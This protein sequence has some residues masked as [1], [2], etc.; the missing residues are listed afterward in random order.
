MANWNWDPAY[1]VGIEVIDHQHKRLLQYINEL[2]AAKIYATAESRQKVQEILEKHSSYTISHFSFEEK[3]MED[4]GYTL[5]EPHKRVHEAFIERVGFFK[6]RHKNGEDIGKQLAF[7]LQIWLLNHIKQEDHDYKTIV[8]RSL[9]AKNI[10]P[11]IKASN[12]TWLSS[13]VNKFF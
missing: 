2:E 1:S 11:T 13:L 4:A 9:Q 12:N 8:Q 3:L 6:E 7:E 5:L 10:Q